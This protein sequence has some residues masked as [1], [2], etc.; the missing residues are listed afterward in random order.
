MNADRTATR[1]P[2]IGSRAKLVVLGFLVIAGFALITEHRAHAL[3][4]LP[5]IILLLCPLLHL[6]MHRGHGNHHDHSGHA[7]S[8]GPGRP[9]VEHPL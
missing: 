7:A 1:W 6:F 5:Y 9:D 4:A 2:T 8:A 3:G